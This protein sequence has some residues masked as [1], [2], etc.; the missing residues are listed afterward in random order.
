MDRDRQ[1]KAARENHMPFWSSLCFAI[2][3]LSTRTFPDLDPVVWRLPGRPRHQSDGVQQSH[4]EMLKTSLR[5][6]YHSG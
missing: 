1:K 3:W 4:H 2:E 5:R 6:C